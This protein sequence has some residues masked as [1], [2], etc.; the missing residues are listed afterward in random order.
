[1]R[2]GSFPF[3]L[4]GWLVDPYPPGV[5]YRKTLYLYRKFQ[6]IGNFKVIQYFVAIVGLHFQWLENNVSFL[7]KVLEKGRFFLKLGLEFQL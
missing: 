5:V 2:I 1:M 7:L 3:V 4:P 6:F